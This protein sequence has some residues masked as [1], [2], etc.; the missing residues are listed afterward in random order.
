VGASGGNAFLSLPP[1]A[2]SSVRALDA[3]S[4]RTNEYVREG[5]GA[6][7]L[8][9]HACEQKLVLLVDKREVQ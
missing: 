7:V 3:P 6:G 8:T 4:V 1:S 5:D 2:P 9:A